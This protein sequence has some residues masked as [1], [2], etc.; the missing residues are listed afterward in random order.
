MKYFSISRLEDKSFVNVQNNLILIFK[1][2][3]DYEEEVCS[4]LESNKISLVELEELVK[5]WGGKIET[6]ILEDLVRKHMKE[7]NKNVEDR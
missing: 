6:L 1:D 3:N 4:L 5:S 7:S 2:I